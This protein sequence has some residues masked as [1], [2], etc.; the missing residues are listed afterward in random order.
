[1]KTLT[2]GILGSV[3]ILVLTFMACSSESKSTESTDGVDVVGPSFKV[4]KEDTK[5]DH[6]KGGIN[7]VEFNDLPQLM[8]EE[9][10]KVIIDF[11]TN[12]CGPCKM[13]ASQTFTDP[14]IVSY[15]N[16][17]YYAIKFN[18][19]GGDSVQFKGKTF[20]NPE[21]DAGKR[22]RN[23]VHQI[24]YYLATVNGRIAYPTTVYLTEELELITPIQGFLAADRIEP[25]LHYFKNDTY[26]TQPN[27]DEYLKT[28]KSSY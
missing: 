1:M 18:A 16:E 5:D 10:R 20:I 14:V 13:M 25:I 26:K 11:Y 7:W 24:T 22:G 9:P 27:F 6:P 21:F 15:I 19:E 8:E 23:S 12:W 3:G 17:N 4:E 2:S 28:F